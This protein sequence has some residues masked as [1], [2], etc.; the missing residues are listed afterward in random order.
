MLK[1]QKMI[2]KIREGYLKKAYSEMN[3][4]FGIF[5][6]YI[7]TIV[8]NLVLLLISTGISL[9]ITLQSK[10]L[11]DGLIVQEWGSVVCIAAY[12]VGIGSINVILSML[13]Q[14]VSAKVNAGIRTELSVK[15]YNRILKADWESVIQYH[16]GDLMTR[17]QEDISTVSES[18]T[19]WI[20]NM[21][22]KLLQIIVSFAII[23]Y[24]DPSM[25]VIIIIVAPAIL[26]GSRVFLGKTYHSNNKQRIAMSEIMSLYKDS[27]QNL[28]A[29]KSFCLADYFNG[30]MQNLQDKRQQL[31]LEVN[32]YS[33]ASW[34]VMYVSGQI[35]A[36]ICLGWAV[37]H[38]YKGVITLGTMTL[39]VM[40]AINLASVF[41]SFIQLLPTAVRTISSLERIR[42]ILELPGEKIEDRDE[43]RRMREEALETGCTLNIR[44]MSFHYRASASVF[45]DVFVHASS[46]EVIAF[47]GPS[48]EGKTTMLR[49]LL[50]IVRADGEFTLQTKSYC[51]PVAPDSRIM[52]AYVPQGNTILNG[53]IA[54][55]MRMLRPEATDEDIVE[56]LQE[57]CAYDFVKKLPGGIY[58][59]IGESGIGL[60]EG[61]NQRLAIARALM[62]RAPILLLDE[63][64]SALDV[65][66]ERKV[67]SNLMKGT[68]KRMC[69]LTTHRPTV[70]SMCDRVYRIAGHHVQKIGET[71]VQKLMNEF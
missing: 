69:I 22:V 43:Y 21:I 7:R 16:S 1:I 67:L 54:E 40:L 34:G 18:A 26:L 14:R 61:Q 33:I 19:G 42:G 31:D 46:G 64:T 65:A 11:V 23:V 36:L 41:K 17:L 68:Q 47:V 6:S 49:I 52:M 30:K 58:Y 39:L 3:W 15:T 28:Q 35:T 20:S 56:A 70:L 4:F 57:A 66:T 32:Q 71:E 2:D 24:Y 12:Y 27:F 60:S 45:S 48:G 9:S 37:Y 5:S 62:C 55:N 25:L 10:T 29:V 51:L 8:F 13:T 59:T 50:G 44:N 38:V 53:T 63:A